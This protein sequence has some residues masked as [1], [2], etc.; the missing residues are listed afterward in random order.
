[1]DFKIDIEDMLSSSPNM[2]SNTIF[3]KIVRKIAENRAQILDD[4]AC[5][6]LAEHPEIKKID[7]AELVEQA[8]PGGSTFYFRKKEPVEEM[9]GE[10]WYEGNFKAKHS[11]GVLCKVKNYPE[12][13]WKNAVVLDYKA[14]TYYRFIT[15]GEVWRNAK[16]VPKEEMPF[17]L[18]EDN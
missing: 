16:S 17:V 5:A 13:E 8:T 7:E 18:T 14:N 2:S 9:K 3:E 4:F 1:M 10:L 6:Y 11:Y 12:T 15:A